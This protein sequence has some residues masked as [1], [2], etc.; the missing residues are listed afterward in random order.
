MIIDKFKLNGKVALVTGGARGLGRGIAQGLAEA[1]A[2]IAVVS[3]T[4]EEGKKAAE[5]MA[6]LGRRT[7]AVQA[8]VSKLSEVYRLIDEVVNHFGRLDVLVNAAGFNI[9]KHFLDFTEEDYES[10]M[11]VQLRAVFFASQRAAKVMKEQGGGKIIN[12]GSLTCVEFAGPNIALYGTAKSGVLGLTRG[13]A[14][15]LAPYNINVN[16]IGPGWFKTKMTEKVFQDE[17]NVQRMLSRLPLGRFGVPED[18]AGAAVF[19][20]SSA[21]D[22]ITGQII[23]VDGGWL[24]N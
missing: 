19:L 20:A 7:L 11:A 12:I 14:K 1:G 18:L 21:S 17:A 3:R 5:E 23:F 9:R 2:D 15:D 6:A 16:A 10:L 22:Y 13:M 24:I 4:V 8:D